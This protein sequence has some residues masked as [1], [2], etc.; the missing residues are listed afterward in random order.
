LWSD[1]TNRRHQIIGFRQL[2]SSKAVHAT[3]DNL[4]DIYEDH[5]VCYDHVNPGFLYGT[6]DPRGGH[7]VVTLGKPNGNFALY[8]TNVYPASI[9]IDPF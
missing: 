4:F 5:G 3:G 1:K 6:A 2:G 9:S 7:N 8:T